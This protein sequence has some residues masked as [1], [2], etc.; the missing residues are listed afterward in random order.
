MPDTD[1]SELATRRTPRQARSR[2]RVKLIMDAT[3][4]LLREAGLAGVTTTAIAERASIPV[5]SLYQYFPNKKAIFVSL[6]EDYLAQFWALYERFDH[7]KFLELGWRE[8]FRR[9]FAEVAKLEA[10]DQIEDELN[11][12]FAIYPD[13]R[14][15]DQKHAD[16]TAERLASL[17]RKL[18]SRW[19]MRRLK[20]LASFMYAIHNGV[21]GY[22]QLVQPP[23]REMF[24]WELKAV[25]AL[26]EHCFEGD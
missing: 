21:W 12:A 15:I 1:V 19:Q 24:E 4:D 23:R 18:G 22:R 11:K 8:F 17:M 14:E 20:R 13:L 7:P 6:Y 2:E 9:L 26:L 16:A 3:R 25:E 5:S 10:R